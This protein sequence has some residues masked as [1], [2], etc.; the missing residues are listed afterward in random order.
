VGDPV[1]Y[2]EDRIDDAMGRGLWWGLGVG[3]IVGA[4][5]MLCALIVGGALR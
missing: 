3:L 1:R 2:F 5:I 4:G